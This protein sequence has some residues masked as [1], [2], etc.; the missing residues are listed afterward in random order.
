MNERRS[1]H[2]WWGIGAGT[3][4]VVAAMYVG[5][6]SLPGRRLE[7]LGRVPEFTLLE[8]SGE[9]FGS[10]D[11]QGRIWIANFIFTSCSGIC[12]IMTGHMSELQNTLLQ[13]GLSTVKL[14]SF[15]V[16]PEVDT[17][18]VLSRFAQKY[19]AQPG[20]WYFLTGR[21]DLIQELAGQG[22]MLSAIVGVDPPEPIIHSN[23]FV[24]VDAARRIRKYYVGTDS[25]SVEQI[26]RDVKNLIA[27]VP[28]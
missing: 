18:E 21:N 2:L 28:W 1:G 26:M 12:P 20:L 10:A 14:V 13:T 22:F 8:R 19:G 3:A 9:P 15:S 6:E 7:T 27:E 25:T 5:Q 4:M 17:P 24:L 11:L 16:D 23:Q